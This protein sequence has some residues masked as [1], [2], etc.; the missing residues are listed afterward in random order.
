MVNMVVRPRQLCIKFIATAYIYWDHIFDVQT[1]HIRAGL[2]YFY[3][4]FVTT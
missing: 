1:V 3:S 2:A 4:C